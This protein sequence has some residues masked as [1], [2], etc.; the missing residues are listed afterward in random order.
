MEASFYGPSIETL[1]DHRSS[2]KPKFRVENQNHGAFFVAA[3][4]YIF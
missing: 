2:A 4:Y 3:W 1:A